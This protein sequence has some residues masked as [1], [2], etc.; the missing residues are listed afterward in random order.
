MAEKNPEKTFSVQE[1]IIAIRSD[2]KTRFSDKEVLF[3]FL[4]TQIT[5]KN[6]IDEVIKELGFWREKLLAVLS[7]KYKLPQPMP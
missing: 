7:K 6:D 1:C 2:P 5:N 3:I 4:N